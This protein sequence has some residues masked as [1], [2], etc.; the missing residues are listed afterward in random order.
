MRLRFLLVATLLAIPLGLTPAAA[1]E[2]KPFPEVMKYRVAWNGIKIG[3]VIIETNQNTYS[4]RMVVDTKTTGIAKM[5]SPLKSVTVASGRIYEG[6]VIPQHY[7]ARSTSDEGKNRT[8]ELRYGEEGL[9]I[10]RTTVPLDDPSWRPEVPLEEATQAYDPVSAF[11]ILREKM[12]RNV[13]QK[14]KDTRI[15]TY[16]GRRLAEFLFKAVNNGTRMREGKIVPVINTVVFRR[17]IHGY[18]P[19]ELK[20]FDEGDPKVHVYFS[21]DTRFIPL[22]VEVYHWSGKITGELEE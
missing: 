21:A 9:L 1:R 2:L 17:P 19:K 14:I 16:D 4:Y 3:R 10:E 5:F 8:S 22:E 12:F 7:L 20:K 6:H 13:N 11:F 15:S 18:T